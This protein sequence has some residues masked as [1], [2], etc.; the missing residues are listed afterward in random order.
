MWVATGTAPMQAASAPG[1]RGH[2]MNRTLR[3]C[4]LLV[5]I[6]VVLSACSGP[7]GKTNP[8]PTLG[9]VSPTSAAVGDAGFTLTATGTGFVAGTVVNWNGA[10][11]TTKFVSPTQITGAVPASDLS[12]AGSSSITV[13]TPAPGGGSSSAVS[14]AINNPTPAITSLSQFSTTVGSGPLTVSI[15]GTR[16]VSSSVVEWNGSDRATTFA[17]PTQLSASVLASD[18]SAQG[19]AQV[20]VKNPAPGGGTSSAVAFT[21]FA[22]VAQGTLLTA[23]PNSLARNATSNVPGT[24][25]DQGQIQDGVILSRLVVFFSFNATVAQVNGALSSVGGGIISMAHG[26]TFMAVGVPLQPSIAALQQLADRLNDA[27]GVAGAFPA[28]VAVPNILPSDP[29]TFRDL[30]LIPTLFPAAWNVK[31]LAIK[32][33]S[34]TKVPVF[35]ADNFVDPLGPAYSAFDTEVPNFTIVSPGT[36]GTVTHGYDVTTSLGAQFNAT[37]PTG[38]NPFSQCL[39]VTGVQIAKMDFATVINNIVAEF[40]AD[41]HFLL[42]LSSGFNDLCT[43][44]NG[45]DGELRCTVDSVSKTVPNANYRAL[46]GLA[47]KQRTF[48]NWN[49]FFVTASAGNSRQ[50]LGHGISPDY[51]VAQ[52]YPGAGIAQYNNPIAVATVSDPFFSFEGQVSLWAPVG[53]A[54]LPDLTAKPPNTA[55]LNQLVTDSGFSAVGAENNALVAGSTGQGLDVNALILSPFSNLNAD[56]TAV[57]EQVTTFS[58][59]QEG[60]SFTAPQVL[61]LA[62]YLWLLSEDLRKNQP[63]SITRQA[64]RANA[65]TTANAG[66][67]IDAYATVL[68]LDAAALP[69]PA[70]APIRA[71]LLDTIKDDRFDELDI[72]DFLRH[73]FLLDPHGNI[74]EIPIPVGTLDFGRYDLNGDGSTTAS[75]AAV[76][77][78]DLDRVGSTQYGGA[79][80]TSVSEQIEGQTISFDENNLSD[81]QI[82]C[83]YAYSDMFVG[84]T[85]ARKSLLGGRCGLTVEPA[86]VTLTFGATQLFTAHSPSNDLVTWSASCGTIDA[87]GFYTAAD[88]AG[89]CS[90]RATS[91]NNSSLSGTATV[92]IQSN[93]NQFTA[94]SGIDTS[95]DGFDFQSNAIFPE[96]SGVVTNT[97]TSPQSSLPLNFVA[98]GPYQGPGDVPN[99]QYTA[100]AFGNGPVSGSSALVPQSGTYTVTSGCS[101][102]GNAKTD[103]N[104]NKI[105]PIVPEIKSSSSSSLEPSTPVNGFSVTV[106]IVLTRETIKGGVDFLPQSSAFSSVSLEY[107]EHGEDP[108]FIDTDVNDG[109]PGAGTPTPATI[110]ITKTLHITRP[111]FMQAHISTHATCGNDQDTDG[112]H[113]QRN[114]SATMSYGFSN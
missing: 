57:G 75:S 49:N 1:M 88:A 77:R 93:G 9:S 76:S 96:Q 104:N 61:G 56:V 41:V 31:D 107:S 79:I 47:W 16:F 102:S 55:Q 94:E 82:L 63:A 100:T 38:A 51:L 2:S 29:S 28:Q 54:D 83:Y 42:N 92:T 35:I 19:N 113:I 45:P 34:N 50:V 108:T 60:T 37:S 106:N 66:M 30:H 13:L 91:K 25:A 70:N 18:V 5:F 110:T 26:F 21:I 74:S 67:V 17:S 105:F 24:G 62:S 111:G 99:V 85:D 80:Y 27:P 78:F 23:D 112:V 97:S 87:N 65:R 32:N 73:L 71:Q 68:S 39:Q 40:P 101:L 46:L 12:A 20:A 84:S 15:T 64:I 22:P 43:V 69:T 89:T 3:L 36:I 11:L 109:T 6:A 7:G 103:E 4:V 33:C 114:V 98:S 48:D 86:T 58:G 81:L 10:E 90:V 14:F 44:E 72:D 52:I 53:E 59:P 95:I 8:T